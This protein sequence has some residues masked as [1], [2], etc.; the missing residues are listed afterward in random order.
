[1][2]SWARWEAGSMFHLESELPGE[3]LSWPQPAVWY[4]LARHAMAALCQAHLFQAQ[5]QRATLWL[6]SFFCADVARACRPLADVREYQ[7]DPRWPE[8]RWNTLQPAPQDLV[9]AVN[10]FGVRSPEPWDAWRDAHPCVLVEDHTQDAFSAWARNTTADYVLCSVR[11][12]FPA[13]DGAFLHSPRLLPL[14][15][16]PPAGDG[17]G[18]GMKLTAMLYKRDYLEG[19]L[20]ADI[21]PRYREL[22]LAGEERMAQAPIAAISPFSKT[23]VA[24]GFP[25]MWRER[26]QANAQRLLDSLSE[27]KGADPLYRSWPENHAPFDLPLVFADSGERDRWQQLLREEN[28]FCPVEWIPETDDTNAA[29]LASRILSLPLDHRYL[30]EEMEQIAGVLLSRSPQAARQ[31]G[32]S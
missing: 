4:M 27:W 5:P 24:G 6:P 9:L 13:P 29:D 10:Y 14:P 31:G 26:R 28:I 8:P 15:P 7:D 23:L 21:K 1:M 2:R 19:R 16:P 18:C 22:Q 3:R 12:T 11:K 32:A 17:S 30:P 20:P 25:A